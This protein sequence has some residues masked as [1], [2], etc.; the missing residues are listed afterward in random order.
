MFRTMRRFRQQITEE[1]C[2]TILREEPRGVL[3]MYGEDGY[4]Y[5]IPINFIYDGRKI[6]F[7]CAKEGHKIDALKKDNRVSFC[8]YDKGYLKEGKVGLNINSVVIFGKIRFIDDRETVIRETRALGMKYL[9]ED[10]VE[11]DVKKYAETG[12]LQILELTID[13][14][15]GKLVNES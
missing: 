4:P 3:S 9:P 13:H 6:Y 7:H 2:E 15:T 1:E 12:R 11:K 5:A 10:L 14:M 8:V